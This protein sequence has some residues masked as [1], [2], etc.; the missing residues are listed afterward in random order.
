MLARLVNTEKNAGG[1]WGKL[2]STFTCAAYALDLEFH[3]DVSWRDEE[4]RVALDATTQKLLYPR[5]GD[6]LE[7]KLRVAE[8]RYQRYFTKTDTFSKSHIWPRRDANGVVRATGL[9]PA[10][11]RVM[12][13]ES[14]GASMGTCAYDLAIKITGQIAAKTSTGRDYKN[15]KATVD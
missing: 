7:D 11:T 4:C 9:I 10:A 14:Y 13:F 5:E 12:F 15:Y 6:A 3:G 2:R 8:A 1:Y